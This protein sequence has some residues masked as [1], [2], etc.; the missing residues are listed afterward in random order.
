MLSWTVLRYAVTALAV[1][2]LLASCSGS[3]AGT[4]A[5]STGVA[6]PVSPTAAPSAAVSA[7][8][9][10]SPS[11][12]SA[13]GTDVNPCSLITVDQVKALYPQV[14]QA[15]RPARA[16]CHYQDARPADVVT[17]VL[18]QGGTAMDALGK[19]NTALGF[20]NHPLSGIGEDAAYQLY[21]PSASQP[22]SLVALAAVK[23]SWRVHILFVDLPDSAPGQ[24]GFTKATS[25]LTAAVAKL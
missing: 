4:T 16:E 21:Q 5:S 7:P 2:V 9:S 10:T 11:G 6:A 22:A 14:T 18:H 17:V 19:E 3:G 24:P 8:T 20:T 23:G 13:S 1:T 25:L 12:S 15:N